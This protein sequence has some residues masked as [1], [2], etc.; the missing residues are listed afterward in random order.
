MRFE[1]SR[2]RL[3]WGGFLT[4]AVVVG[5]GPN[6]LAAALTLAAAG[7]SVRVVEAAEVLGGGVRSAA[8]TVSGLIHDECSG[9]HPFAPTSAFVEEFHLAG[10]GLT[11]RWAPFEL[12]HPLENGQGAVLH[13]SV[14]R[15]AAG[16]GGD[17]LA[18]QQLFGP[19]AARF[20]MVSR[21]VLQPM[22]HVPRHP[23]HLA[24]FG[25]YAATS[26]SLLARRW[27]R[28]EA[29]GL[30]G[31]IAAHAFTRLD[32]PFSSAIGVALTTA[33][34][35]NGWPVAEG[36]SSAIASA[37]V[38]RATAHG[39]QFET[40]RRVTSVDEV[41]DVDLVMLDVAPAA[42]VGILAERIPYRIANAYR[43]YRHG[44]AV[45]KID[46]A[47]EGDVPWTYEPARRAGVVHLG[48]T[49]AELAWAEA[50]TNAGKLAERPFIL[51][52]QQYVADPT[53]SSNGLNPVYAYA[54]VP[55]GYPGSETV[56]EL[57]L[58]RIEHY[59]PGLRDRVVA[60]H[61]RSAADMERH[62]PNYV[63][64]DIATG[65]N[66][67]RQLVFR[68][69]IG[70][71]PYSTGARGVFLCSAATPPGAGAHGMCGYLAAKAALAT[72]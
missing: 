34:H 21:D 8:L 62:N 37:I 20:D 51:V 52:G 22:V 24:R 59:A 60:I 13:R 55:H 19:L 44:A 9:F 31:G 26:A 56:T 4:S 25:A 17:G 72:L 53:R 63:G 47:I 70:H 2:G 45:H 58:A 15:T 3:E 29:R 11:W 10:A 39:V 30:Y 46:L 36:G 71:S 48:G 23:W 42:A 64:G 27:R 41:G 14:A 32:V 1:D 69:R 16:L 50:V 68:P 40:G 12:A 38:E 7:V 43:R 33:A 61:V 28:E 67:V 5:S 65:A 6:G 57:M 18:W 35:A 49:L 54:H 66:T